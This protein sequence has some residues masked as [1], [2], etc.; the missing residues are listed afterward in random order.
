MVTTRL[1]LAALLILVGAT[2][3]FISMSKRRK[4]YGWSTI[5]LW[6]GLIC[7]IAGAWL[8][9]FSFMIRNDGPYRPSNRGVGNERGFPTVA[10]SDLNGRRR[11]HNANTY[12]TVALRWSFSS[13][14][15]T[16]LRLA[17]LLGPDTIATYC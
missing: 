16:S 1:L 17:V 4:F 15:L 12:S 7:L 8:G 5:C 3:A 9:F 6:A 10:S 14:V 2:L 13:G 11:H